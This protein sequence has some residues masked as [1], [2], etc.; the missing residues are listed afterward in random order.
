MIVGQDAVSYGS[1]PAGGGSWRAAM[2]REVGSR[3][4][5]ERVHFLGGLPYADY[6]RVLQVSACHVY[7][8][9][10]F[11]LSWSCMEALSA[12]CTV[13]GSRTGPVEEV[14]TDG[15][16]GRLV[17]FFDIDG[18][19]RCVVE[20]LENPKDH[21][22]MGAAA[23]SLMQRAYDINHCLAGQLAILLPQ[24]GDVARVP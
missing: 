21:A 5:Q 18:L 14:I 23:R 2:L 22:H 6:L 8:T 3:L 4:P 17:D 13:V 7:L 11:V 19:S 12:G 9:Y 20:V 24:K 16:T 10:P 1:P 15:K